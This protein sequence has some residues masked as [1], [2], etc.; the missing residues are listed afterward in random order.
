MYDR[1]AIRIDNLAGEKVGHI[2][3]EQARVLAPLMD[4]PSLRSTLE[5][6]ASIP[7][8]GN[9]WKMPLHVE[10]YAVAPS[11]EQ[12]TRVALEMATLLDSRFPS[13][14]LCYTT[15]YSPLLPSSSSSSLSPAQRQQQQRRQQQQQRQ[16]NR[17]S[18]PRY[19]TPSP[20]AS[21]TSRSAT[22]T[23]TS[24]PPP[25][26]VVVVTTSKTMDWSKSSK[27]LDAMFDKQS[28]RQLQ[29]LPP[30]EIPSQLCSNITLFDHQ[31]QG[32][33]WLVRQET[34][35]SSSSE[36]PS[37]SSSQTKTKQSSSA[38]TTSPFFKQVQENGV[39]K[40]L[41]DITQ[42]SQ[43]APPKPNPK[44]GILADEMGLGKTLQTIGLILAAPPVDYPYPPGRENDG[45]E[46]A[47]TSTAMQ[48]QKEP[49]VVR[50]GR[51]CT[52]IVCPVSVM[53]NWDQQIKKYVKEGV[54]RVEIF[55]GPRRTQQLYQPLQDG[56]IDVLLV[57]YHTL[58][59]DYDKAFGKADDNGNRSKKKNKMRSI[60]NIPF[61]RIVL[62][63]AHT[64]RS[65]KTNFFRAVCNIDAERKLALTGTPF[66]NKP[67][68][69]QSLLAFLGVEPL[70]D[71]KIFRRAISNPIQNNDEIGMSRLRA[72]MGFVCLRR[73]KAMANIQMVEK[74]VT[75]RSVSFASSVSPSSNQ[76]G[77][78]QHKDVYDALFGT[79]RTAFE[80]VLQDGEDKALKNYSSIFEKLMRMRQ[81]CCSAAL[82]PPNRREIALK[83]WNELQSLKGEDQKLTM[84]AEEGMKLLETLKGAFSPEADDDEMPECSVCFE[85]LNPDE[86]IILKTCQ[87]IFCESCIGRVVQTKANCPLCRITFRKGDMVK[88]NVASEAAAK[89]R[90]EEAPSPSNKALENDDFSTSPKVLA[91]L[92]AIKNVPSDEKGV[93][94]SQL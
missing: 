35:A 87:H 92:D 68:D 46:E 74:E 72:V 78:Q 41:C 53:S 39:T 17:N 51:V 36:E 27:E 66:V 71:P 1:N 49:A 24:P 21:A 86:C 89:P 93:I 65:S 42:S 50:T 13:F 81:A 48:V 30:V 2:K 59:A 44:G 6:V 26:P 9:R 38:T 16:Y 8:P 79:F 34:A 37:A 45:D 55:Q 63:E 61:H 60:F 31:R 62:D 84:T 12:A 54:L 47:A 94:F 19:T 25:E 82:V 7:R 14:N 69:C 5:I 91:L 57:S 3:R 90:E 75:L 29:D 4:A 85:E 32:I 43:D 10:Y 18:R 56:Q 64:V 28:Q 76:G 88:K 15:F 33:Q 73:S 40:W 20:A 80:A 83:V 23:T 52:L 22:S 67:A 77:G 70:D 58:A 11:A